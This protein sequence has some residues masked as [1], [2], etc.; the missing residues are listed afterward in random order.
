M[1]FN[2]LPRAGG[3]SGRVPV[4][5]DRFSIGA[6]RPIAQKG[7]EM[8]NLGF[9]ARAGWRL[10]AA[11]GGS[12]MAADGG[13]SFSGICGGAPFREA[14]S[15]A[16]LDAPHGTRADGLLFGIFGYPYPALQGSVGP[17]GA[18]TRHSEIDAR[19]YR[20]VSGCSRAA[21][22]R[23]SRHPVPCKA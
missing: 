4:P 15:Y 16:D 8:N 18:A 3:F 9:M 12:A 6:H 5:G 1:S 17:E 2:S 23:S 7:F 21:A 20:G 13:L 19:F 10:T 11:A 22:A 14:A